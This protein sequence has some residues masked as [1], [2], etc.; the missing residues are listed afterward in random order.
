MQSIY[1]LIDPDRD[2]QQAVDDFLDDLLQQKQF[3]SKRFAPNNANYEPSWERFHTSELDVRPLTDPEV[4]V[5][6]YGLITDYVLTNARYWYSQL[7]SGWDIELI[8][9]NK[10]LHGFGITR[11]E[12]QQELASW[13]YNW[14]EAREH[15][16]SL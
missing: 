7:Y 14:P 10:P 12:A 8:I 16:L 2:G 6:Q 4:R 13:I 3:N 5:K 9:L 15:I 1:P 11:E